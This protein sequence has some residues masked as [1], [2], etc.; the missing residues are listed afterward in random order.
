MLSGLDDVN[1]TRLDPSWESACASKPGFCGDDK[2]L[3]GRNALRRA[4]LPLW[5]VVESIL[6]TTLLFYAK[7]KSQGSISS[8]LRR[9]RG[10]NRS[11][12]K[13]KQAAVTRVMPMWTVHHFSTP[14]HVKDEEEMNCTYIR[15]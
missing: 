3:M 8:T 12:A 10:L 6:S 1:E 5:L 14:C 15:E 7:V 9:W 11:Q 13:S 2:V 4:G